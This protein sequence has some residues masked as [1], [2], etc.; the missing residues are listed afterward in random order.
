MRARL[1]LHHEL[2]YRLLII[3][4]II[5][6]IT[7]TITTTTIIIAIIIIIIIIFIIIFTSGRS[8]HRREFSKGYL[9]TFR[10]S[11]FGANHFFF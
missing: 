1:T 5:I 4:I 7:I 10:R 11:S 6:T 8:I 2:I 9:Y 3:I